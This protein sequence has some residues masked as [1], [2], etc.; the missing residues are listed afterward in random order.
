MQD[1]ND[2]L[3]F[4]E[5]VSQGSF[6]AAG[7]ALGLPKSR[8]SRRVARLEE[9]LGVRLL[10]R[11]T[12]KLSLTMAGEL[13][14]RHC[15]ALREEAEAAAAAVAQIQ[16]EPRGIIRVVCPVTLIQTVIGPM[17]PVYQ[18][19][20]PQVQLH[21]QASNRVV[22]L[23]EEGVDVALRVRGSL[24]DSGSL[25]V[26]QLGQSLGVLVASP[27][28]LE[29]QGAPQLPSDL[30]LLDSVAM[31]VSDGRAFWKLFGPNGAQYTVTH[32]PRFVADD[33]LTLK[34]AIEGGMG[35]GVLPDY[36]CRDEI[37]DGRLVPVLPGWAPQPGI[38]HAVFASRRGLAPAV[39]SFLDFLGERLVPEA[40]GHRA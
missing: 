39:R 11:T 26:K 19:R 2:M 24:A 8:L 29:R 36:M 22:D 21:M 38:I 34:F 25:V 28:Q 37:A 14:Y 23:V 1:L 20:H 18:A 4:A 15:V 30:T 6:A 9:E 27:A 32:K 3:Y 13:Y 7:R 35:L 12:R 17:L 10:Q 31:S 40:S 5:V 33:L 16:T